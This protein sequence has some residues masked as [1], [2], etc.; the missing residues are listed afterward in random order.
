LS[1][2]STSLSD[3]RDHFKEGREPKELRGWV[4]TVRVEV[5][6]VGWP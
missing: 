2:A 6:V 1:C 5:P 4:K 3:T